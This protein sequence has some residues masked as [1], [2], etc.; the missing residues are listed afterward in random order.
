MPVICKR[1]IWWEPVA[2]ATGYVIHV[3]KSEPTT[4]HPEFSWGKTPGM[5]SKTVSARK[6]DLIIPD[7]WPEFPAQPG[8]YQI[9][10]TSKDDLGNQSDPFFMSGR[11]N[12]VAP[13]PPSKGGIE[14]LPFVPAESGTPAASPGFPWNPDA[15]PGFKGP[16]S[17]QRGLDEVRNNKELREVYLGSEKGERHEEDSLRR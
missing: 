10:V 3:W 2:E 11:F 12:F 13:P 14:S 4:D 8:T 17:I 16:A 9:A 15:S 5:I 6:S 7:E 1:R